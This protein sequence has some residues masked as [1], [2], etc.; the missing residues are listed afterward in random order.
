MDRLGLAVTIFLG[1]ATAGSGL[2]LAVGLAQD[3]G[4]YD[5]RGWFIGAGMALASGILVRLWYFFLWPVTVVA[6]ARRVKM[7]ATGPETVVTIV[8]AGMAHQT[9]TST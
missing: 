8:E 4:S 9:A 2:L 1:L 5:G 3:S 7:L 6:D